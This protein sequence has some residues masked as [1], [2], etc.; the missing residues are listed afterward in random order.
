MKKQDFFGEKT[1]EFLHWI[2]GKKGGC[3]GKRKGKAVDVGKCE[4]VFHIGG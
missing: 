4:R 2:C 3:L 1:H